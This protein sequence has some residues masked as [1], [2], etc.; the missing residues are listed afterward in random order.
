MQI[1]ILDSW[2]R[3]HLETAANAVKIGEILTL[4][5]VSVERI[6]KVGSDY[7]YDIE[8]TTNRPDLMSIKGLAREAAVALSTEGIPAKFI[9]KK[10]PT[11]TKSNT[12]FPVKIINDPK[13]VKRILAVTMSVK[14]D[15]SP[16]LIKDRLEATDIR[17]LNNVVDVTNYIMRELGHPAHVFDLDK[18]DSKK[19]IIREA[20]KGETLTT[21]DKKDY[22]L[23]GYEI[24]ADDGT[25]KIIDLLGIMGTQNS[26]VTDNTKN[27]ILFLDNN[28]L[29]KIRKTSMN[30][31]IRTEA[32]I[33]NEKG[34]D[35]ELMEETLLRGVQLLSEIA[36]GVVT[37]E[38]IDIYPKAE[39][40]ESITVPFS[41]INSVIGIEIPE[42]QILEILTG[43]GF[44]VKHTKDS[45][46]VT[47]PT[48]RALDMEIPEDVIEEIARMYGYH[49][50]PSVLPTSTGIE[51]YNLLQN[52][53]FWQT[54]IKEVLCSWGY[55]EV[56]TQSLVSEDMLE[57]PASDAVALSNPLANDMVYLRTTLTPGLLEAARQNT[58]LL[59]SVPSIKLFELSNVYQKRKKDLPLELLKLSL[60][61]KQ[62]DASFYE[63]KGIVTSLFHV[64]GI[65]SYEFKQAEN[66]TGAAIYINSEKIGDVEVIDKNV[67]SCEL[68][69]D[70]LFKNIITKKTFIPINKFPPAVEDL[71][72]EIQP[73]IEYK[74]IYDVIKTASKLVVDIQLI[75]TYEDKK[76]FRITYQSK[77]R[78]LTTA[79]IVDSRDKIVTA[80]KK[81]LGAEMS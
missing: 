21:L 5:S 77:E 69:F 22:T 67:V 64:L 11:F 53:F 23:N 1:K 10:P 35:P 25:G 51:P 57:V 38:I 47:P 19:M 80:L 46:T 31:G 44:L 27:I 30:L 17:S 24:V 8:I 48:V 70:L 61:I 71:R 49:K 40:P 33:I 3:E 76:T 65:T 52:K 75:D 55:S 36:E 62:E 78:N 66:T 4:K 7:L 54:R 73:S 56:Y 74:K 29:H 81:E 14:L 50:L 37:S 32:A 6:E 16:Q 79:D 45:V 12:P 20:K 18:L 42:K 26:V 9:E 58:H 59:K 63:L 68:D 41:K 39:K 72:I 43:L 28:D 15:K 60:V 34:V 2:L 13:L